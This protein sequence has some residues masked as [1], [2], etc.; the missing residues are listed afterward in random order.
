MQFGSTTLEQSIKE[1]RSLDGIGENV[2]YGES[3]GRIALPLRGTCPSPIRRSP[4]KIAWIPLDHNRFQE[5]KT[6]QS[7]LIR[8]F[9]LMLLESGGCQ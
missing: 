7:R 6:P 8:L 9:R 5:M 2:E 3:M 1:W 4:L